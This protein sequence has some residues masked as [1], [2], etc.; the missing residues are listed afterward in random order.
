MILPLS[1][2]DLV[3]PSRVAEEYPPWMLSQLIYPHPLGRAFYMRPAQLPHAH[4]KIYPDN[5]TFWADVLNEKVG[6]ERNVVLAGFNVFDWV[7]RNPGLFHTSDAKWARDM[8]LDFVRLIAPDMFDSYVTVDGAPPDR[9]S[10]FFRATT[11]SSGKARTLIFT[12]Q[13]KLSMLDGGVGCVRYKSLHLKTGDT[14]WLMSATSSPAPDEGIPLMVPDRFYQSFCD[15]LN[16]SGS[17]H[18]T[19]RGRTRFVADEFKDL[20]SVTRGIP[21]LYIEVDD[22]NPTGGP[23]GPGEVSVAASFLSSFEGN[24]KIYASYVT[25]DPGREGARRSAA[26]WLKEEYVEHLYQGRLL[27]DFDQ[28][29]PLFSD[30]LF[31]LD[32]VLTSP[33][34]TEKIAKLSELYGVFD[35]ANLDRFSY[36]E[37]KGDLIVT[38]NTITV[39]DSTNVIIQNDIKDSQ[40]TAT[41]GNAGTSA[42]REELKRL[43]SL[44]ALELPKAPFDQEDAAKAVA[45]HAKDLVEN[46]SREKPNRFV[47]G[48]VVQGLKGAAAFLK[49]TLPAVATISSQIVSLVGKMHGLTL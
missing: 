8:A 28:R 19:V 4:D 11:N 39:S 29:A 7:P 26:Q 13:G 5:Q 30:A 37:H 24:P 48:P 46:A 21:R 43:L 45:K 27:T 18:C 10:E 9:A 3:S 34:L 31:T 17:V 36:T 42:E 40:L 23:T 6:A 15:D 35:W 32:Q 38:N 2:M 16:R 14:V 1:A 22:L 47:L 49:D 25:F 41:N 33:R 12:P 20:Y 44:L